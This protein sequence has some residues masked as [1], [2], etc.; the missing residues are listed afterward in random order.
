MIN[1]PGEIPGQGQHNA[2]GSSFR[3][4]DFSIDEYKPIKVVCIG[5]G[6]SGILAGIRRV[7]LVTSI[8][9]LRTHEHGE[10]FRSVYLMYN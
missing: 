10:D 5:A 9:N 3:L 6:F 7:F 4:G 8:P 2:P 1:M